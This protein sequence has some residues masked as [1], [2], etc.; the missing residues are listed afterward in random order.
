[1]YVILWGHSGER[2]KHWTT[3]REASKYSAELYGLFEAESAE[4]A[5]EIARAEIEA[6]GGKIVDWYAT[7]RNV[8]HII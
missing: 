6:Q 1:M 8:I 4:A 3:A 2:G 7:E 5:V